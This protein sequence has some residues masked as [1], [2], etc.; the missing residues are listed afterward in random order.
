VAAE[1]KRLVERLWAG[2]DLARVIMAHYAS[3]RIG[4]VCEPAR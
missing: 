1:T 4:Q 3:Q 2:A